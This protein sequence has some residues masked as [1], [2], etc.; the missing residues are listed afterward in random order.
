MLQESVASERSPN[1]EWLTGAAVVGPPLRLAIVPKSDLTTRQSDFLRARMCLPQHADDEGPRHVWDHPS[2]RPM[3]LGVLAGSTAIGAIYHGGPSYACD[4]AWWLDS[5]YRGRGLGSAM[6]EALAAHLK[7][8][9]IT[10]VGEISIQGRYRQQ[11][12]ALVRRLKRRFAVER[13]SWWFL[14]F[15]DRA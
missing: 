1:I 11:S 7:S 4:V 8:A 2:C 9:G 6:V 12:A 14:R 13:S 10:G 3:L 5:E 15:P